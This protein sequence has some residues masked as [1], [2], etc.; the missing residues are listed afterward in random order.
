MNKLEELRQDVKDTMHAAADAY[1]VWLEAAFIDPK[2]N[3]NGGE[4]AAYHAAERTH[5]IAYGLYREELNKQDR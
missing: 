3:V 4:L 5:N 2:V 1:D